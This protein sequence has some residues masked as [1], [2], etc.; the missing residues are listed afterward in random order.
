MTPLMVPGGH[1]TR[2]LE[3]DEAFLDWLATA[4]LVELKVSA[5]TGSLLLG[6]TGVL[7]GTA[8]HY[9]SGYGRRLG[10]V[11]RAGGR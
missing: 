5:C 6:A 1:G 2:S 11:L 7:K 4:E 3:T 8:R 9:P 10:T